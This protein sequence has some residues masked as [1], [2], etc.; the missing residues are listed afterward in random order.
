M[1]KR[2]SDGPLTLAEVRECLERSGYLLESRLVSGL[3]GMGFFVE[4]NQ[5]LRDSR[6]G[7]SREIDLVAEFYN[8]NKDHDRVCVKSYF[9]VE[10][11]N[12]KYPLVLTT[13]RPNTPNSGSENYLKCATT[14]PKIAWDEKLDYWSGKEV[15][16]N[17]IYSQYCVLTRKNNSAELMA[18]HPEDLYSSLQKL[19]EYVEAELSHWSERENEDEPKFWRIFYWRPTLVLS[20]ELYRAKINGLGKLQ[21][22]RASSGYLE[23][24]WHDAEYRCTALV[25]VITEAAFFDRVAEVIAQDAT[26][27]ESLHA[28]RVSRDSRGA[29]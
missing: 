16:W 18:T 26:T 3:T 6:T 12:N 8:W 4:P 24:N 15:D 10:A 5:V 11:V 23:F 28:L 27:E 14:L 21:L 9:V 7:K 22:S 20:G 29:T 1:K 25:E 13:Q 2:E 19:C 17:D